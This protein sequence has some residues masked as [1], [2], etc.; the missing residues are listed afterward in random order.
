MSFKIHGAAHTHTG[1]VR[2]NNED[3]FYLEGRY[4]ENVEQGEDTAV[5][6]SDDRCFLA[7][8]A[9]GMGGEELGEEAS[10]MA[11]QALKPCTFQE[12]P[13]EAENA[14]RRGNDR[15]CEEMERRGN[16]RMGSTLTALYVDD[17][18]AVCCNVGDSRGYLLRG[19]KLS[20]LS[21][22]HNKAGRMVELGVLTPE[23][24]ARHPSR[25]ELTQHLG[26]FADEMVIEPAMS[27]PVKLEDGDL[28]LLCSDGLT[29]MVSP[30]DM[31]KV[32]SGKA[33]PQEMV[34]ELIQLAL[35]GGGRDNVTAIVL[36]IREKAPVWRRLFGRGGGK[37]A[38]G[39]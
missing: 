15:I 33:L 18:K 4:R 39:S 20:Q 22:D 14:V 6:R 5:C 21:V 38:E 10:L 26:I 37:E 1:C 13:S 31:K 34:K 30:E 16:R 28:F 27:Q 29:D 32:L 36:Q 11:V 19:G 17:G 25:H 12:I 9:D 23:Q 35:E 24:A 7:A 2:S 3:N 8:V